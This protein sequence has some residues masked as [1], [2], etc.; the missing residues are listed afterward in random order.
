VEAGIEMGNTGNLHPQ[1]V[2]IQGLIG[3]YLKAKKANN[4]LTNDGRHLDED[5]LTAFV[6]GNL[7][8]RESLPLVNHL[9][10]CSFCLHITAELVRL[11]L[12]FASEDVHV[13]AVQSEQPS[14]ISE[15][16]NGLLSRIFGT[17]DGVVFAHEEKE[18]EDENPE[19]VKEESK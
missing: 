10:D 11:D 7:S 3:R 17:N 5:S 9:V 16:L 1:E 12:A 19:E 2:K 15:V 8:E 4:N 14:K 18:K 13:A 6:E